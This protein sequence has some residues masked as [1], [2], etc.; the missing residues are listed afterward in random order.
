MRPT[1]YCPGCAKL[2]L[3]LLVIGIEDLREKRTEIDRIIK[4]EEAE[5]AKIQSDMAILTKRLANLNDSLARKVRHCSN[6]S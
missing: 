4:E 5:K 6:L 3:Y 1:L 2:T